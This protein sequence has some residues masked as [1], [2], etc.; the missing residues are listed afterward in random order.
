MGFG[1]FSGINKPLKQFEGVVR[2]FMGC[3]AARCGNKGRGVELCGHACKY[4]GCIL[5]DLVKFVC[6]VVFWFRRL[7]LHMSLYR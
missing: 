5:H 1:N 6:H 2:G 7:R 3:I 4:I